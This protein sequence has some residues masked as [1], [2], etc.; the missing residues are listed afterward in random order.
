MMHPE[1]DPR[2]QRRNV[3]LEK[4]FYQEE[5]AGSPLTEDRF[6][7]ENDASTNFRYRDPRQTA[8]NTEDICLWC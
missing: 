1:H 2:E 6:F 8:S 5:S 4:T 7:S 3:Y